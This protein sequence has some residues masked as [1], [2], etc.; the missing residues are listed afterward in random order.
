LKVGKDPG[1]KTTFFV[2]VVGQCCM[3]LIERRP[4]AD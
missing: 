4:A 3:G 1:I 2:D